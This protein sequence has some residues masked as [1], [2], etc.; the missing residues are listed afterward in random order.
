[1][2]HE[3]QYFPITVPGK[4]A[5]GQTGTWRFVRPVVNLNKCIGCRACWM[6]CPEATIH[7][8]DGKVEVDYDYCKG[9]GICANVCPVKAILMEGEDQ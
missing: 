6:F 4:G 5:G 2:Q 9:C 3:Y 8:I 1:M 7:V